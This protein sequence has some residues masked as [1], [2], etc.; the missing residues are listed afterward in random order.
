MPANEGQ[1]LK[2][3][4]DDVLHDFAKR[5][6][7]IPR[8][9]TYGWDAE[10][11]AILQAVDEAVEA[12]IPPKIEQHGTAIDYVTPVAA[13]NWAVEDARARKEA[14]LEGDSK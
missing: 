14:L 4:V 12:V 6:E 8:G 10:T 9:K 1:T 3:K 2:E 11:Q 13:Y 5:V 7:Q